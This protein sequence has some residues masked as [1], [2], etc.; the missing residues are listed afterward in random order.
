MLGLIA[1]TH[2]AALRRARGKGVATVD[3]DGGRTAEP[4]RGRLGGRLDRL[5]ANHRFGASR[6]SQRLPEKPLGETPVRAR[7]E[8]L[9][10]ALQTGPPALEPPCQRTR[11]ST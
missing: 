9:Q 5:G 11:S 6:V 1:T 2:Q 10:L 4:E 7:L 8:A 3:E